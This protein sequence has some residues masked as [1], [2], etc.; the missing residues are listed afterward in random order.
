MKIRIKTS[1]ALLVVVLLG[2]GGS[3]GEAA[4]NSATN[5]PALIAASELKAATSRTCR[6][7]ISVPSRKS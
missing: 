4:K 6:V 5:Y 1:A 7:R 3:I 2:L